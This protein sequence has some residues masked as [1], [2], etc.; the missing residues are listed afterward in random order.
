MTTPGGALP[1]LESL[2]TQMPGGAATSQT[3]FQSTAAAKCQT[4]VCPVAAALALP[5]ELGPSGVTS[6]LQV[7]AMPAQLYHA[8][9]C[10]TSASLSV[11]TK[12][13]SLLA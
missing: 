5:C 3:V 13:G 8:V 4:S 7:C 11:H 12:A 6:Q 10:L 9:L 1:G 2:Y